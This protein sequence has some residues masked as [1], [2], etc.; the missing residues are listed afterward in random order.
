MLCSNC[1]KNLS[2]KEVVKLKDNSVVC[3]KCAQNILREYHKERYK[4]YLKG[5]I[6]YNE[7]DP[8]GSRPIDDKFLEIT[9]IRCQDSIAEHSKEEVAV[10]EA[11]VYDKCRG[12][13]CS[14]CGKIR[15]TGCIKMEV[16]KDGYLGLWV[17]CPKCKKSVGY[18]LN[19]VCW[20]C[21]WE[22]EEK[23]SCV[24]FVI[25]GRLWK[26]FCPLCKEVHVLDFKCE[27]CVEKINSAGLVESKAS[28]E[29]IKAEP[30]QTSRSGLFI[31]TAVAGV[32]IVTGSIIGFVFGRMLKNKNKLYNLSAGKG[33]VGEVVIGKIAV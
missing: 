23:K 28:R 25:R 14:E 3:N 30:Q 20:D 21:F 1:S 32:I 12:Q 31:A 26:Y 6:N 15:R 5:E 19:G 33:L 29:E 11:V 13:K 2:Q 24:C 17:N 4:K 18:K 27:K 16:F 7:L 9:C 8:K 10:S 22:N